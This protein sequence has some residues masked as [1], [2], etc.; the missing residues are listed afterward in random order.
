M[1]T[2]T[3]TMTSTGRAIVRCAYKTCKR[4][5]VAEFATTVTTSAY[6]GRM[7]QS[8][9]VAWHGREHRYTDRYDL[10]AIITADFTCTG[11]GGHLAT[12]APVQGSFSEAHKCGARCLNA[13]GPS[14][15]CQCGGERHGSG[16]ASL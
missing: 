12:F 10:R 7:V 6:E 11:C 1:T 3:D 16:H 14:C 13:T 8:R 5:H 15:E 9:S 2:T 4:V